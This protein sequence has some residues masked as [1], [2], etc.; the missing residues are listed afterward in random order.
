[1]TSQ[2]LGH[3]ALVGTYLTALQNADTL[4]GTRRR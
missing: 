4:T 1:M 3:I 2:A